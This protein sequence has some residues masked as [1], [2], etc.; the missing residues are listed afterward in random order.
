MT[1]THFPVRTAILAASTVGKWVTVTNFSERGESCPRTTAATPT[2]RRAAPANRDRDRARRLCA[3]ECRARGP[4]ARRHVRRD[5]GR[6]AGLERGLLRLRPRQRHRCRQPVD[7]GRR[8]AHES[9]LRRS[10]GAASPRAPRA[11]RDRPL[12]P[13]ALPDPESPAGV[14]LLDVLGARRHRR[15]ERGRRGL[16]ALRA[17]AHRPRRRRYRRLLVRRGA[18]RAARPA[19]RSS[20]PASLGD[21]RARFASRSCRTSPAAC[22]T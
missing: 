20:T 4:R 17:L 10:H 22:S 8:H 14:R 5:G 15:L 13:L 12:L 3:D 1:V 19:D 2:G 16:A 6:T 21:W 11:G 9:R 7:L 18:D